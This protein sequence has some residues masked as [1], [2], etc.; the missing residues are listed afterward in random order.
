VA[1]AIRQPG[2]RGRPA[3]DQ[4]PVSFQIPLD[5][6]HGVG[7]GRLLAGPVQLRLP[8]GAYSIWSSSAA[9][10]MIGTTT[11]LSV[12]DVSRKVRV[13]AA[14]VD[15]DPRFLLLTLSAVD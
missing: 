1:H 10:S 9:A 5:I 8:C 15:N 12:G 14:M 11:T 13:D 4:I 2:D 6:L 7:A 3:H